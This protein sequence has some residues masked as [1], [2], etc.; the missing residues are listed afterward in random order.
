MLKVVVLA[1]SAVLISSTAFADHFTV[2]QGRSG[3]VIGSCHDRGSCREV[4]SSNPGRGESTVN[5]E[6]GKEVDRPGRRRNFR[7]KSDHE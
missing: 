1:A 5:T 2:Y 6:T 4:R 7:G 3:K